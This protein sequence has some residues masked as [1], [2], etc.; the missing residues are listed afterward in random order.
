MVL[1]V[2]VGADGRLTRACMAEM[3]ASAPS[4]VLLYLSLSMTTPN[5]APPAEGVPPL[6]QSD[7]DAAALLAAAVERCGDPRAMVNLADLCRQGRA[8]GGDM[9]AA[10]LCRR[11][12]DKGDPFGHTC[13]AR[14]LYEGRGVAQD[15]VEAANHWEKAANQ[16]DADG[17]WQMAQTYHDSDLAAA[18]GRQRDGAKALEL[19][20]AAADAGNVYAK[21][22]LN[23]VV[24]AE[25]F[26]GQWPI[27][28]T[29][30]G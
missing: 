14:H 11:A 10:E 3:T 8:P 17:L 18:A 13:Y 29:S 30:K 5:S 28:H 21:D 4:D 23:N 16:G 1:D 9:K 20:S 7:A 24:L 15:K 19:L 12:A 25:P 6:A 27:T 22:E 2:K 26:P